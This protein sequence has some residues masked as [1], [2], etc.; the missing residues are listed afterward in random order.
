MHKSFFYFILIAVMTVCNQCTNPQE[1]SSVYI[2]DEAVSDGYIGNGAEWDPYQLNYGQGRMDISDADRQKIYDRLDFM[3]PRLMRVMI[4]T[5]SFVRDGK[6]LPETNID[7]ISWILDYCQSHDVTVIFG[8]W[9]GRIVNARERT[10]NSDLIAFAAQYADYLINEKGFTCIRHYNLINEPNGDW[11]A[12]HG[13]YPLWAK[14]M[15][16]LHREFEKLG[17]TDKLSLVGPDVAIWTADEAWWVDSCAMQMNDAIG[18][19]DIHTYP[20]KSTVN[21]GEYTD[22]INAYREKVSAGKKIVMGEIG[23]KFVT[24]EDSA[25][26]RENIRRARSKPYASLD[27]SQMFVYDYVYGIDMADALFQTA[28]AGYS[29]S[30]VWMLDDAMHSKEAPD[31]LKVWGF[32]NIFGDEFFGADEETVRP[33]YYAWS[34]L[35]RNMPAGCS[36]M[37]TETSGN[38]SVKSVAVEKDNNRMFALVNVSKEPKTVTVQHESLADWANVSKYIY[39]EGTLIKEGDFKLLP[40]EKNLRINLKEGISLKMPGESLIVYTDF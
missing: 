6:L 21:S 33:W 39:A 25:L 14:A 5:T 36:I 38:T 20:S 17:L 1:L 26:N 40:N 16:M 18:L 23:L 24:A 27:D 4:N 19:Y 29:G 32:W 31:K 35:C 34:L 8:D 3:Q 13:D 10:V 7:H 15:R 11:S 12:A 22:I 9:G 2:F 30:V 28:N 37:K